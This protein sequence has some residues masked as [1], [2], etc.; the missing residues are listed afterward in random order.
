MEQRYIADQ[1]Q[2]GKMPMVQFHAAACDY[3]IIRPLEA[4][5]ALFLVGVGEYSDQGYRWRAA[6]PPGS[7]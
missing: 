1:K 5:R 7:R 6:S 3:I 2:N 4:Q